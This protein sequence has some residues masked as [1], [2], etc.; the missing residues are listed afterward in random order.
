MTGQLSD[1][2]NTIEQICDPAYL[3][4]CP[5]PHSPGLMRFYSVSITLGR[6]LEQWTPADVVDG[7]TDDVDVDFIP[8]KVT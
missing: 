7:W 6:I 4:Q 2:S 8:T 3:V 5:Q 1:L